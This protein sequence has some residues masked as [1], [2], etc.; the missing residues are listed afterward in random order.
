M[1][2]FEMKEWMSINRIIYKIY[3]DVNLNKMR[4]DFLEN[5]NM[6]IDFDGAYFYLAKDDN[7]LLF[8][9]PASY[10]CHARDE[11]DF[12]YVPEI[13]QIIKNRKTMVFRE[14]DIIHR[15]Q[16]VD[17]MDYKLN[18]KP[19]NWCYGM[20]LVIAMDN[21][22]LGILTL[23]RGIGKKNFDINEVLFLD[24]FKEHLALRLDL[25]INQKKKIDAMNS[26]EY[27]KV[28]KKYELTRKERVVLEML[29]KG[30]ASEQISSE[31][32]VSLNTVKKHTVNIYR[33][34]GINKRIQLIQMFAN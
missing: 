9:S 12:T 17:S 27:D 19:Y 23:F 5:L 6:Y 3:G 8:N 32:D 30:E 10:R 13:A 21:K 7:E 24:I 31:L 34:L 14:T 16:W 18:Y 4:T 22:V 26:L 33:K 20:R 2:N 28:A 25:E 1:Q 11:I 29:S 15:N